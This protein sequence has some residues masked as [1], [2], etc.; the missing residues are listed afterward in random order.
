M[1]LKSIDN[2]GGYHMVGL[3]LA[4]LNLQ[5]LLAEMFE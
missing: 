4:V 3:V 1:D 5:V 2:G